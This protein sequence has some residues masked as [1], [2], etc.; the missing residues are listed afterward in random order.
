ML[1]LAV[2]S[3]VFFTMAFIFNRPRK[4]LDVRAIGLTELQLGIFIMAV[5]GIVGQ[6]D[7]DK[8]QRLLG[9]SFYSFCFGLLWGSIYLLLIVLPW[10]GSSAKLT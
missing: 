3:C 10:R 8:T 5:C 6:L 4:H 7:S 1:L 2:A 9:V